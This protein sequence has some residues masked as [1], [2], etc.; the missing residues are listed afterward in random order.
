MDRLTEKRDEQGYTLIEILIVVIVLAILAAIVVFALGSTRADALHSECATTEKSL[1]WAAEVVHTKTGS[2]PQGTVVA[3]TSPNPLVA[4]A[5][6]AML[7]TYP[8]SPDYSFTYVGNTDAQGNTSYVLNVLNKAGTQ[9]GTGS[10][11]CFAL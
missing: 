8:T 9:V 2:Y 10:T 4:P 6:G 1:E 11:G 5:S 7:K 3:A